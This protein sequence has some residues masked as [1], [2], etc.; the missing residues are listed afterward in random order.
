V[1]DNVEKRFKT[2]I[3]IK[4]YKQYVTL[5]WSPTWWTKFLFIRI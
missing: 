2:Y 4:L 1:P 5:V 3:Y